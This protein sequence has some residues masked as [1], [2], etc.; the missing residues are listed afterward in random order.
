MMFVDALVSAWDGR[1]ELR[2]R[3]QVVVDSLRDTA[4]DAM[5]VT[6]NQL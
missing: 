4:E 5:R 3:Q 6:V 1:Y 2:E